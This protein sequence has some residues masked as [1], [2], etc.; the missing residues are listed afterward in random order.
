MNLIHGFDALMSRTTMNLIHGFDA[1]M[2]R[3][4]SRGPNNLYVYGGNHSHEA[5]TLKIRSR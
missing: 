5:V 4:P 3:S 1:L 2:S